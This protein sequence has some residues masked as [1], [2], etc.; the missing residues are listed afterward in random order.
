MLDVLMES[1]R[2]LEIHNNGFVSKINSED[3]ES[4]LY[5]RTNDLIF[6]MKTICNHNGV[7]YPQ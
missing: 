7:R 4:D 2:L 5:G 3:C 6:K 1:I